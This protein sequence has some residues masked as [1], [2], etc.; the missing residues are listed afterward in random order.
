MQ[1]SRPPR[2]GFF[3]EEPEMAILTSKAR[4]T[5]P[6]KEFGLPGKKAYP[7]PDKAHAANAKARATQMENAGKLSSASKAK[8]DTKADKIL[9]ESTA[10]GKG[11][12]KQ[13][14]THDS[15]LRDE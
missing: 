15:W 14:H 2:A 1:D 13:G 11:V 9:G 10:K 12:Q 7:M 8:I 5:L 4:N 3:F 6:P